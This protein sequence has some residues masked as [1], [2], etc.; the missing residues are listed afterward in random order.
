M[1]SRRDGHCDH[2]IGYR[3]PPGVLS[4]SDNVYLAV[5]V[6]KTKTCSGCRQRR[7]LTE[8][9]RSRRSTDVLSSRCKCCDKGS[10]RRSYLKYRTRV[11]EKQRAYQRVYIA[12]HQKEHRQA[13]ALWRNKNPQYYRS[14]YRRHR[15]KLLE[16]GRRYR[17][18][19][20]ALAPDRNSGTRIRFS[21]NR[22]SPRAHGP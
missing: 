15:R 21:R 12:S 2:K 18:A 1:L 3:F 22:R 20:K 5:I 13:S 14:Y 11:L 16:Y 4:G 10:R 17:E 8:Y 6:R 9:F 19:K 7:P